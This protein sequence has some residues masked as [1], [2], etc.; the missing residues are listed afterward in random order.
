MFDLH[1]ALSVHIFFFSLL[2]ARQRCASAPMNSYDA[3]RELVKSKY[4]QTTCK[5]IT[6]RYMYKD[7]MFH[8]KLYNV[9][10]I[11]IQLINF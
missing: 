1:N 9:Q 5:R 11:V 2:R 3:R 6:Y 8:N 4:H 10:C 7:I